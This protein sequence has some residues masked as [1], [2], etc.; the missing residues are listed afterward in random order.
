MTSRSKLGRED[1][2]WQELLQHFRSVQAKHEKARRQ[3]LGTDFAYSGLSP[4][5][6]KPMPMSGQ[7]PPM[8]RK[9]T[10]VNSE[11]NAGTVPGPTGQRGGVLSPLNP[12]A[13]LPA[14]PLTNASSTSSGPGPVSP[15]LQPQQKAKR[16][17]SLT[18][19]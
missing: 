3:T 5:S 12:R 16:N 19:K 7:R 14:G 1:I 13:R 9:V 18:R 10:G 11:Q 17:F 6:E 4:T 8:R 15:T 2:K